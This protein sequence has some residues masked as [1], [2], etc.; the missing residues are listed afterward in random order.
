M[1]KLF[2][3]SHTN[4]ELIYFHAEDM[5]FLRDQRN[6]RNMTFGKLDNDHNRKYKRKMERE[7]AELQRNK[8]HMILGETIDNFELKTTNGTYKLY[9]HMKDSW[10]AIFSH[11]ADFTPVC[12]TELARLDEIHDKFT[13]RNVKIVCTSTD[14]V[15]THNDWIKDIKCLSSNK[16]SSLSFD[17]VADTDR[18][19]AIK[20]GMLDPVEKDKSG[21]PL[22]CRAVLIIGP[23]KKLKLSILY[24]ATTGRNF[25]E[26]LRVIDSVQLT[27]NKKL[28]TPAD[29]NN[30]DDC[31]IHPNVT[32][33]DA[34]NMY[35]NY[36]LK[37][38]PSNKKYIR[39]ANID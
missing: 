25:D 10:C 16:S 2:D 35:P 30:G 13:K 34:K 38:L 6:E 23:D 18:I 12:T 14:S 36:K 4:A 8:A 22:T 5:C 19:M 32:D 20:L 27:A 21:I 31:I 29:W 28:T 24:P 7:E 17:I 9:N 39:Y 37:K 3:I 11:P 26:I 1:D 33:E 15:E